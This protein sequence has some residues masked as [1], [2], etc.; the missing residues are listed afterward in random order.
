MPAVSLGVVEMGMSTPDHEIA[1]LCT[2]CPPTIAVLLNILPVHILHLGSIDAVAKAKSEIFDGLIDR[3]TAILNAD[4]P[5]VMALNN[6]RHATVKFGMQSTAD[7]HAGQIKV[8]E[9]GTRFELRTPA[10][11]QEIILPMLGLHQVRNAL[12][13]ATVAHVLGIGPSSVTK[14]LNKFR[15]L[16]QRGAIVRLN[17]GIAII[18]DSYNSNPVSLRLAI[19]NAVRMTPKT[20]RLILVLGDM[21]E[22]GPE[23][24]SIHFQMGL[25][26]GKKRV[27]FVLGIGRLAH[28]IVAG[29][30]EYSNVN[31]IAF[32]TQ[33]DAFAYLPELRRGDVILVKGSRSARLEKFVA[34]LA[35]RHGRL[36]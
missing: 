27:D 17:G 36:A 9:V 21:R 24:K 15:C 25:E 34:A 4:D 12:A 30:H 3:G 35:S 2:I 19:D 1:R 31:A 13:A 29:L 33:Q 18:D 14:A 22:L 5:R 8:S 11:H 7:I 26:I 28:L 20:G 10:H 32:D 23:E 16:P 6:I